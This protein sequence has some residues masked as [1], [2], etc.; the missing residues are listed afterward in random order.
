MEQ[1]K[2]MFNDSIGYLT[3]TI[4]W[5]LH[6]RLIARFNESGLNVTPK[7]WG[8]LVTIFNGGEMYQSQLAECQKK[9]R[10]GIKRLVDHLENKGLVTREPSA[11][12]T[13]ANIV[14]LTDEGST[15]VEKLNDIAKTSIKDALTGF[16]DTE[17][18]ILKVLLN[19]LLDNLE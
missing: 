14:K 6:K 10:A 4:H 16:S 7:Q 17:E 3:G 19:K 11:H 2:Y 15:V 12:D 18:T 8:T 9:D 13:R 1:E 5:K